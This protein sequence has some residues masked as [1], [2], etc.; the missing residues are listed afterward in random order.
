MR[1]GRL[2]ISARPTLDDPRLVLGFSGWMDGGEVST[3][4]AKW[5]VEKLSCR[6]IAEIDAEG[7]YIYN[8]PGPM[9]VS[10]LFRPYTKIKAGLVRAYEAPRNVFFCSEKDNLIVLVGKEPNL[11]WQEFGERVFAVCK[12]FNVGEIYFMGSVAGLVPHT[13]EPR[14]FCSV[15]HSSLKKVFEKYQLKFTNYEGPSS[16]VTYLLTRAAEKRLSMASLVAEIPAYVQGYNPKCIETVL[17]WI[18]GILGLQVQLDELRSVAEEFER[19]LTEVVEKQPELAGSVRKL[20][21][22]YDNEVFDSEMGDLKKWLQQ[23]GIRL[24]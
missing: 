17:R 23:R 1:I 14:M 18:C 8:L 2:K 9:E 4:C 11:A 20:E 12:E 3:G 5:L 21:E 7:F 10:A 22:D 13:R 15:S 16:I 24:D 19:K 6:K